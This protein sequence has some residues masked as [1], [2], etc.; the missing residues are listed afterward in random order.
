MPGAGGGNAG[1]RDGPGGYFHLD[2]E[3][4]LTLFRQAG[5]YSVTLAFAHKGYEQLVTNYTLANAV[6]A[7]N[8]EPVVKAG[9]ILLQPAKSRTIVK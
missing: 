7:T 1:L 2:S 5:W 3:R 8:G 9:N 4:D 6:V